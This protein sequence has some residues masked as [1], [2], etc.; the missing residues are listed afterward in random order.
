MIDLM[1]AAVLVLGLAAA[2]ICLLNPAVRSRLRIP[3][4]RTGA[5]H[6]PG[7]LRDRLLA[8]TR[9]EGPAELACPSGETRLP[10]ASRL[11]AQPRLAEPPGQGGPGLGGRSTQVQVR[12]PRAALATR[13]RALRL[14]VAADTSDVARVTQDAYVI[15]DG[16]IAVA[17]GVTRTGMDHRAAAITLSTVVSAGLN[18]GDDPLQS[19]G[20]CASS[21]NKALRGLSRRDPELSGMVTTLDIVVFSA[22]GRQPSFHVAHVGNSTIWWQAAGSAAVTP[23]TEAHSFAHGPLLRAV[24]IGPDLIP[25][26]KTI[27][28]GPGDR[29][30]ICTSSIDF[31]V[32]GEHVNEL[33]GAYADGPLHECVSALAALAP[34]GSDENIS[35]VAAEV[36]AA[37]VLSIPVPH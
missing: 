10:G 18:G 3:L 35:V 23:V 34:S 19:L 1:I 7:H 16:V 29:I 37:G 30:F 17:R 8:R 20:E 36:S 11:P 31:S 26:L 32:T 33:A 12:K 22:S 24:G 9:G 2:G 13:K 25:D 28:A 15:Q 14:S 21:A 4:R 6:S 27:P 5:A